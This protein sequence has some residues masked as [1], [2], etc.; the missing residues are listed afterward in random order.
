MG[1]GGGYLYPN[2]KKDLLSPVPE[3]TSG[4]AR[5]VEISMPP[6]TQYNLSRSRGVGSGGPGTRSMENVS[7]GTPPRRRRATYDQQLSN[8]RLHYRCVFL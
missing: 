8:G 1:P 2:R 7:Q 3:K 4:G 6:L 5:V